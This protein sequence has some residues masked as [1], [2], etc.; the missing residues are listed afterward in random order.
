MPAGGYVRCREVSEASRKQM[1]S[2]CPEINID[3]GSS[4]V[5]AAKDCFVG[6]CGC[7]VIDNQGLFVVVHKPSF[8]TLSGFVLAAA[9]PQCGPSPKAELLN[10]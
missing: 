9:L 8:G 3:W 5:A 7:T 6:E 4:G 1:R 10:F 2:W